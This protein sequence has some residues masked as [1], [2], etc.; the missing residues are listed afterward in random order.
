MRSCPNTDIDPENTHDLGTAIGESSVPCT[1]DR[2]SKA[3]FQKVFV[4]FVCFI[5]LSIHYYITKLFKNIA[6]QIKALKIL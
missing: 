1:W 2:K 6:T 3:T 4:C 5:V